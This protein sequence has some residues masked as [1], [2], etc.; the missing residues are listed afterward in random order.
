MKRIMYKAC[1]LSAAMLLL[2]SVAPITALADGGGKEQT[3]TIDGYQVTLVFEP[4]IVSGENQIH[5]QIRDSQNQPVSHAQVEVSVVEV[6]AEHSEAEAQPQT[7]SHGSSMG[8]MPGMEAAPTPP[9]EHN[10]MDM[11]TF[12]AGHEMGE[13]QGKVV[14]ANPDDCT[15]RVHLTVD[16]KLV[17]F[18]F[19]LQVESS[20]T[21]TNI[22]LGFFAINAVIMGA[23]AILKIKPSVA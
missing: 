16:G 20:K 2:L 23:A 3:Q 14:I 15:L 7:D 17:E 19:P 21:G 5:L 9:D 4:P 18:D 13:Y 10:S 8:G 6:D 11:V 22:L 1:L 12:A